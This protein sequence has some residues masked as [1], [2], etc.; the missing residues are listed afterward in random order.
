MLVKIIIVLMLSFLL[1]IFEAMAMD[2]FKKDINKLRFIRIAC[3]TY[4][5]V[6]YAILNG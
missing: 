4:G 3:I 5:Y 6:A 1:G 2:I